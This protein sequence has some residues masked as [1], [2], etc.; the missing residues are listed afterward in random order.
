MLPQWPL[1]VG[2][3]WKKRPAS[4]NAHSPTRWKFRHSQKNP[5][6]PDSWPREQCCSTVHRECWQLTEFPSSRNW[7]APSFIYAITTSRESSARSEILWVDSASTS[8]PL[9]WEGG[10]LLGEQKRCRWCESMDRYRIR[11]SARSY[12]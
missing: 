5:A 10:K 2:S 7:A 9:L 6:T 8:P 1:P 12:K 11:Y 3:P 4:A